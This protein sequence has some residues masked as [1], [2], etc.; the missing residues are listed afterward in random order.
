MVPQALRASSLDTGVPMETN[1][2]T[3]SQWLRSMPVWSLDPARAAP[4]EGVVVEGPAW[5]LERQ[6]PE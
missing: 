2:G 6:A 3:R 4:F 1:F 5:G